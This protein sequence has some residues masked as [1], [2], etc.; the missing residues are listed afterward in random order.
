MTEAFKQH[1]LLIRYLLGV[2]SDSERRVMEEQFFASDA[3]LD[4]LLKA[5]DELIDDYVRGA[6]TTSDRRLF[7]THF[8]C[9]EARRQRLETVKSFVEDF[10]QAEYAGA[11]GTPLASEHTSPVLPSHGQLALTPTQQWFDNFLHWLDPDIERAAE[12]YEA[13]RQRLI[14]FFAS[15]GSNSPEELADETINRVA[16]RSAKLIGKYAGDP[17]M[18]FF[19]VARY[20]WSEVMKQQAQPMMVEIVGTG[21]VEDEAYSCLEKCFKHLSESDRELIMEFYKVEKDK[22]ANRYK[23]AESLGVSPSALRSR[24]ARIRR[25]LEGCV[26]SCLQ[27]NK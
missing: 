12:K 4:V 15:K 23:L 24:V 25:V 3:D 16:L 27:E 1:D 6:L 14:K 10:A 18:Y 9:T 7:E 13:I 5:E 11:S 21:S 22:K 8:L 20:V 17:S 26:R 2:A 19:G